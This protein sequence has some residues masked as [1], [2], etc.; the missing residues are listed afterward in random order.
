MSADQ[1]NR[2]VFPTGV[3]APRPVM[4]T[5]RADEFACIGPEAHKVRADWQVFDFV[6]LL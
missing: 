3:T 6:P 5:L 2:A 4:A 1:V